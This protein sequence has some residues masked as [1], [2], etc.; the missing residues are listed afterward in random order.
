MSMIIAE[1]I[2]PD[3]QMLK[4]DTGGKRKRTVASQESSQKVNLGKERY[5]QENDKG[6]EKGSHGQPR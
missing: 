6:C 4:S 3:V 5:S 2:I 1:R